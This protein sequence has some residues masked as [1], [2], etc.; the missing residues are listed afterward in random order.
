MSASLENSSFPRKQPVA[1]FLVKCA[2]VVL[3]GFHGKDEK[4]TKGLGE[5]FFCSER[6]EKESRNEKLS[7]LGS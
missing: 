6:K 4:H 2:C 5:C 3:F 1:F 7:Y